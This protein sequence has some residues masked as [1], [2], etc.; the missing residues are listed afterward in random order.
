M[1][2]RPAGGRPRLGDGRA[3]GLGAL[4]GV[5]ERGVVRAGVRR[6]VRVAAHRLHAGGDEDVALAGPDG[7]GR[8]ADGLQRRGAVAV[9]RDAGDVVAAR[10]GGPRPGR[11]CSP[12][13]RPAGRSRGS[14]P[15]PRRGRARAPCPA[16]R[17]RTSALRSSGR[18]STSEP[19]LARPIG[20]RPV[21]T[22]T[23]SGMVTAPRVFDRVPGEP[24]R[25]GLQVTRR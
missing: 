22:M 1:S 25:G 2:G 14:R 3:R 4:L 13:R 16:R 18:H 6:A 19:L 11:C 10:P 5:G 8:H 9:H 21:A 15:R 17:L 12:P 7:V 23:A 20:V 24:A